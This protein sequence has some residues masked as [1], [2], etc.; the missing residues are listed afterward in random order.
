MRGTVFSGG[1]AGALAFA[2][3][4]ATDT[5]AESGAGGPSGVKSARCGVSMA[6][7]GR[8]APLRAD[9]IMALEWP[10]AT[11]Q[12]C[13]RRRIKKPM[14]AKPAS[15][16]AELAG[17]GTGEVGVSVMVGCDTSAA[18]SLKLCG[19]RCSSALPDRAQKPQAWPC[20]VCCCNR[21]ASSEAQ[22]LSD[23]SSIHSALAD[24]ALAKANN[25][26]ASRLVNRI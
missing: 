13:R 21:P 19:A 7:L 26:A 22:A 15:T 10:G 2:V 1:Q 18:A 6:G 14:A 11:G 23:D 17:S 20:G 24:G 25:G 5:E 3:A 16:K 9:T 4:T 8:G 12:S